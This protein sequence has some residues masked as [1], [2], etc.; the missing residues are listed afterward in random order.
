MQVLLIYDVDASRVKKV[1]KVCKKYMVQIQES[2]F[3]TKISESKYRQMIEQLK[4]IIKDNDSVICY[5]IDK[6]PFG[7]KEV[8]GK[9]KIE[10][11]IL[12]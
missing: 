12:L 1:F 6:L 8:F 10:E 3:E 4:S 9:S 7:S 11:N 2:V 5:F